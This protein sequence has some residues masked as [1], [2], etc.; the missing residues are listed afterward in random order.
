MS[1]TPHALSPLFTPASVAVIGASSDPD[2][3][4]GRVLR[5]LIE[6]GFEGKLYPVN[7]SGAAEI[8]GLQAFASITDVPGQVDQA[9]V[10]TPAAGVEDAIRGSIAKGVKCVLVLTAGFAEL[11]P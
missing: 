6:A 2:R 9:I 8:Q 5:F 4:G 7:R 1:K 11:G 3:I 10:L